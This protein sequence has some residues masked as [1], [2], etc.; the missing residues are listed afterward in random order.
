MISLTYEIITFTAFSSGSLWNLTAAVNSVPVNS[1]HRPAAR[2]CSRNNASQ[3]F[4]S[5]HRT[6]NDET[7]PRV[8]HRIASLQSLLI[9]RRCVTHL[10]QST[11]LSLREADNDRDMMDLC[12]RSRGLKLERKQPVLLREKMKIYIFPPTFLTKGIHVCIIIV[13]YNMRDISR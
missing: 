12:P 9:N 13:L 4:T 10:H 5:S 2:S 8:P 3:S 7:T 6:I 11:K 1:R